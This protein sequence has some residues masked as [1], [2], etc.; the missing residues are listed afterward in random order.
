MEL[1]EEVKKLYE[2]YGFLLFEERPDLLVFIY[3]QG[4]FKNA[5]VIKFSD[6][7]VDDEL[8]ESLKV[9]EYTP[10]V[11][12]FPGI[13]KLNQKLFKGF[14]KVDSYKSKVKKGYQS[15]KENQTKILGFDYEYI[16]GSYYEDI[17]LKYD[18]LIKSM[19]EKLDEEGPQLIVLEAAAGYGKTCTVYELNNEIALNTGDY[20][21]PLMT[22][23]SRNRKAKIFRYVLLDEIDKNFPGLNSELVEKEIFSGRIPVIVDGFDELLIRSHANKDSSDTVSEFDDI[24][25]MLRTIGEMLKGNAKIILTSRKTA[26]LSGDKFHS[27][28][29]NGE[30]FF[31]VT[32]ITLN[33]PSTRDWIGLEKTSIINGHGTSVGMLLNPVILAYIKNITVDD[34]HNKNIEKLIDDYFITLLTREQTRQNIR[35][36]VNEQ[37]NIFESLAYQMSIN[38]I[39]SDSRD[40]IKSMIYE[41]N[42][43]MIE[44]SLENYYGSDKPDSESI[45]NT[46]AGHVL[47]DR[48][49]SSDEVGFINEFIFGILLGNVVCK[50]PTM[51]YLDMKFIDLACT[52]FEIRDEISKNRLYE[53][54]REISDALMDMEKLEVDI[55]LKNSLT[56]RYKSLSVEN[57]MFNNFSFN[58]T[59]E[60]SVFYSC[61]FTNMIF[62]KSI[63]YQTTFIDCKFFSCS[64]NCDTGNNQLI[65][66]INCSSDNEEYMLIEDSPDTK[67]NGI[68]EDDIIEKY[69]RIVIEQ[70]WPPGK[71]AAQL[72]RAYRTLFYGVEHIDHVYVEMAI[73]RLK[74]RGILKA[75]SS[76]LYILEVSK[77]GEIQEIKNGKGVWEFNG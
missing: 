43:E 18:N 47:L 11:T 61:V 45:A 24:E 72:K 65:H 54:V 64:F 73:E 58:E 63:F 55:K 71:K 30:N 33:E 6:I 10:Q 28:L 2:L 67:S 5:E 70:F 74:K 14:F 50:Q 13:E 48:N 37:I 38:G 34:L 21:I 40:N 39:T 56:N 29:N 20:C 46:L 15:F 9:L 42:W 35:L 59:L 36:S 60:S 16:K 3:D 52:S 26:L 4:Y 44:E 32:R 8:L 19:I 75:A 23:L 17:E 1:Q 49:G 57:R 41:D 22:E 25:S 53:K 62:N 31:G 27:W 7:K 51:E 69:E 12:L 68:T 76:T 77:M 66:F